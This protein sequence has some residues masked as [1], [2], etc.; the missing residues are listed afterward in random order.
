MVSACG[1][2]KAVN[3]TEAQLYY[4]LDRPKKARQNLEDRTPNTNIRDTK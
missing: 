3:L 2:V 1:W 4:R